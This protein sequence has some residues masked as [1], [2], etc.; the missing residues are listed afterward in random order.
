MR[1]RS[2]ARVLKRA[3]GNALSFVNLLR[4]AWVEYERDRAQYLAVAMIYYAMVSLTTLLVA[5]GNAWIV[6]ACLPGRRRCA[7]TIATPHRGKFWNTAPSNDRATLTHTG[8]GVDRC[9]CRQSCRPLAGRL[10][11]VSPSAA[12]FSSDLEV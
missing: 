9:D 10:G 12:D 1:R 5:A 7:G 2:S 8:T 11:F 4:L 3:K 6:A